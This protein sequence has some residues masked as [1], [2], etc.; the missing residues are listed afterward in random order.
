MGRGEGGRGN[1]RD[2]RALVSSTAGFT[3]ETEK[4]PQLPPLQPHGKE[5]S[6]RVLGVPAVKPGASHAPPSP[7]FLCNEMIK[8]TRPL[9][10]PGDMKV[11]GRKKGRAL[12]RLAGFLEE[13]SGCGLYLAAENESVSGS[14][15]G[16]KP[17][18]VCP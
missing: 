5:G 6:A 18:S 13:V 10:N 17:L 2:P 7:Q 12:H 3:D 1:R 11:P 14:P 9:P 16:C 4:W 15:M 8:R